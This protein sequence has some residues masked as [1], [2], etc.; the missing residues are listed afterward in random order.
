ME[1][2]F[3]CTPVGSTPLPVPLVPTERPRSRDAQ[4]L[5]LG[6]ET[7]GS[8]PV[9]STRESGELLVPKPVTMSQANRAIGRRGARVAFYCSN[10]P[11]SGNSNGRRCLSNAGRRNQ[12]E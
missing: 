2:E 4:V 9:P 10:E 6:R 8:N 1:L 12:R 3:D 5:H 11:G 7:D